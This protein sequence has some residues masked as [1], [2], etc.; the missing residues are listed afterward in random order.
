MGCGV[1]MLIIV[2][3]PVFFFTI[4]MVGE[5]I[6]HWLGLPL[7]CFTSLALAA[8]LADSLAA[9]VFEVSADGAISLPEGDM[10]LAAKLV[11]VYTGACGAT[12]W[13]YLLGGGILGG[14][15]GLVARD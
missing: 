2:G 8:L 11:H 15:I 12:A 14:V 9:Q 13:G 3:L 6:N 5:G 7:L 4:A 1:G 10:S